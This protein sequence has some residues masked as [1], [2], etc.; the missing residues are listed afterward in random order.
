[1]KD[2][3]LFNAIGISLMMLGLYFVIDMGDSVGVFM[4]FVGLVSVVL[5]YRSG[6]KANK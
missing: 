6:F 4:L 2:F 3:F 5:G 1:M